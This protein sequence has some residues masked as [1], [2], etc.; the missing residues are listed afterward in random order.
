MWS[1][2]FRTLFTGYS[3]HPKGSSC[4][5]MFLIGYI[6]TYLLYTGFAAGVTS[7]LAVQ[8]QGTHLNFA[9]VV[10]MRLKLI[11]PA[12]G[13]HFMFLKVGLSLEINMRRGSELTQSV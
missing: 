7:L 4:R 1:V 11:L 8:G 3:R 10:V 9:D 6:I 5:T 12:K 2:A 13:T